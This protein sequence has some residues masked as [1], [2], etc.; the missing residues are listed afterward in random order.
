MSDFG[1]YIADRI[2]ERTEVHTFRQI[3]TGLRC[4]VCGGNIVAVAMFMHGGL[5]GREYKA[6]RPQGCRCES[7]K[8]QYMVLPSEV[9]D[10]DWEYA[11]SEAIKT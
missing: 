6:V 5:P 10:I 1:D 3:D 4:Q 8:L 7:C 11:N 9:V 2:D